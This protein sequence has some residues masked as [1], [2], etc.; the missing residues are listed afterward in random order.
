MKDLLPQPQRLVPV[1]LKQSIKYSSS[2]V[3]EMVDIKKIKSYYDYFKNV[4]PL[5][6]ETELRDRGN[7][8]FC[9]AEFK[10][11]RKAR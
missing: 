2:Y 6:S 4:N 5:F 7:R 3:A 9:H 8:G 10:I 1:A 11:C